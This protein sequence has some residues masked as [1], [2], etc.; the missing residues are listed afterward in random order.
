MKAFRLLLLLLVVWCQSLPAFDTTLPA[1]REIFQKLKAR[2][3]GRGDVA[4]REI[5]RAGDRVI[6]LEN[7]IST[8]MD[9]KLA[10]V[11][12]SDYAHWAQWVLPG[13]NDKPDGGS[14]LTQLHGLEVDPSSPDLINVSFSF[15]VPLFRKP[16]T[17]RFKLASHTSAGIYTLSGRLLESEGTLA[18]ATATMKIFPAEGI[19]NRCWLYVNGRVRLK[20]MILYEALPEKLLKREASERVRILLDNYAKEERERETARSGAKSATAPQIHKR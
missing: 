15:N 16:R 8:E 19:R 7:F 11:I 17:A 10:P 2:V 13:I 4:E 14:Y 5:R 1:D 9:S 6:E 3:A 12:F 18:E 20:S